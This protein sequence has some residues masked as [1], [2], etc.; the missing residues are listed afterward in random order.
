MRFLGVDSHSIHLL[1]FI[2]IQL[3]V[4][5]S[6]EALPTKHS[7]SSIKHSHTAPSSH[8]SATL[9]VQMPSLDTYLR[10]RRSKVGYLTST[11]RENRPR[12]G[13]IYEIH[14][15]YYPANMTEVKH[16]F[17]ARRHSMKSQDDGENAS[18]E[19]I[20]NG[21]NDDE[22]DDDGDGDNVDGQG[23]SNES[24]GNSSGYDAQGYDDGSWR[25]DN[26]SYGEANREDSNDDNDNT[27]K[28]NKGE[29]KTG[30]PFS[31][32]EGGSSSMN[33]EGG[34]SG[35]DDETDSSNGESRDANTAP[36]S[37]SSEDNVPLASIKSV[38]KSD[39][40]SGDVGTDGE[41][42]YNNNNIT[43]E[44]D[45][46]DNANNPDTVEDG[47]SASDDNGSGTSD[48]TKSASTWEPPADGSPIK[49]V[50]KTKTPDDGAAENETDS[51]ENEG[52]QNE[53]GQSSSSPRSTKTG[54][55]AL[56]KQVYD[57]MGGTN[58]TN[59]DGWIGEGSS[60]CQAFGVSCDTSGRVIALDLANNGLSGSLSDHLFSLTGLV[61]L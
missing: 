21:N 28:V 36:Y 17:L 31:A 13:Q 56:L 15:N 41:G 50:K 52:S 40:N 39:G 34:S 11:M 48:N 49:T 32:S 10:K 25:G 4:L 42:G 20:N 22:G 2:I 8:S 37:A 16:V 29:M 12:S 61:K 7:G 30:K 9:P 53:P 46:A 54:D 60:C 26:G 1:S 27:E 14:R 33:D 44:T 3:A 47:Q 43:N 18:Q 45:A 6:S 35:D 38:A 58:W 59:Q 5:R 51:P 24:D 55:C 57:D 23:E 19:K